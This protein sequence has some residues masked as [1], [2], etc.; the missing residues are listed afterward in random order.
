MRAIAIASI[1]LVSSC[2]LSSPAHTADWYVDCAGGGDFCTIQEAVDAAADGDV[3]HIAP[4][5]Y[6]ERVSIVGKALS[7]VGS[8]A[9]VTAVRWSGPEPTVSVDNAVNQTT[10]FTDLSVVRVPSS[11]LAFFWQ[12]H[13][14]E[15]TRCIIEGGARGG[16]GWG[17][18][19]AED[20]DITRLKVVGGRSSFFSACTL[21]A[22]TGWGADNH[23]HGFNAQQLHLTDCVAGSVTVYLASVEALRGF[24]GRVELLG[25]GPSANVN[26]WASLEE[27]Q[28]GE[29]VAAGG[30]TRLQ[31]CDVTGSVDVRG[32]RHGALRLYGNLV[33]GD[34]LLDVELLEE[35]LFN[36]IRLLHNTVL[37]DV[38]IE[39]RVFED[40]GLAWPY[41]VR[42]NIVVGKT[43]FIGWD[44]A[45]L[46]SVHHNDFVGGV[47]Y[48]AECDSVFANISEGPLFCPG[49]YTLQECSPCGGAASDDGNIG[50][51][52]IAC[53]CETNVERTSWGVV[54]TM[55]R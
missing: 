7:L 50:A 43:I 49:E 54:K 34:V 42:D 9:G 26:A 8:G 28:V 37:G 31:N 29:V 27:T 18:V 38:S 45:C 33:H 46:L 47:T 44:D 53:P 12:D 36:P 5:T 23:P 6:D 16:V 19:A 15:L 35:Y 52:A 40:G 55:F 51:R 48:P 24:V 14:V 4:C 41:Q 39:H 10:S 3:I 30:E 2:I 20:C 21:G 11:G 22:L 17:E 13:R 25:N 1:V 32:D